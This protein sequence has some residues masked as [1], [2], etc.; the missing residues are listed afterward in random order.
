ML[1]RK[2]RRTIAIEH[3]AGLRHQ[4]S[5]FSGI[6]APEELKTIHN[7]VTNRSRCTRSP[8]YHKAAIAVERCTVAAALGQSP[9][10]LAF[11]E[12]PAKCRMFFEDRRAT[13]AIRPPHDAATSPL[14]QTPTRCWFNA[15]SSLACLLAAA[16][17]THPAVCPRSRR[18]VRQRRL[19]PGCGVG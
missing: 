19:W 11:F 13:S 8:T 12:V 3:A 5:R 9:V 18:Q 10:S 7:V 6:C 16:G 15:I 1:P 4:F 14:H 2:V 17:P